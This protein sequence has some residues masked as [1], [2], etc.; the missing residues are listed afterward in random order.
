MNSWLQNF[1]YKVNIDWK[2]FAAASLF[3]FL[4]AL[5]TVSFQSIKASLSNPVDSLRDE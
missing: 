5:I 2:I 3:A 4:I 1:A